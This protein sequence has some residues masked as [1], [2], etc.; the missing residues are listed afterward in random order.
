VGSAHATRLVDPI[1]PVL[2]VGAFII[3]FALIAYYSYQQHQRR[4]AELGALANDLSWRF[5]AE[6]DFDYDSQYAQFSKFC[7]GT[8]RYAYN[9]LVG[10]LRMGDDS[11]PARM[12]DY[13]YQTTS[14]DGKTTQT[15]HHHFSYLL[16]EL[17][18]HSLPD[19]IIRREGLFDKLAGAFG[20][21]D[22]DFES[23]EFSRRFHVKSADKK[24]AYDVCHAHMM[25]FLLAGDPPVVEISQ[26]VCCITEGATWSAGEFRERIRFATEFF[27]LWPK[28][29]VAALQGR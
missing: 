29:L 1:I 27:Q 22:I 11:W 18:Y 10:S 7:Q 20:F 16:I 23:S 8:G 3:A 2:A 17:P 28:H 15:H 19:L 9:T 26:D 24:F 25:E 13:H 12:G 4:L 14:S 6:K 5:S 21:D